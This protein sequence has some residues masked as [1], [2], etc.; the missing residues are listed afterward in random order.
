MI[1]NFYQIDFAAKL[2][3][4]RS[5]KT[6]REKQNNNIFLQNRQFIKALDKL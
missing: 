4:C 3:S 2:I 6:S 5:S 1:L